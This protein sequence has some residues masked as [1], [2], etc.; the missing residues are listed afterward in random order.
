M[1][2]AKKMKL[3]DIDDDTASSNRESSYQALQSDDKF[4][5]SR[6][7]S[8]LD[9][10]MNDI[11]NRSDI[12]DNEKWLLYNQTLQKFLAYM[13]STRTTS[14]KPST[15]H[16]QSAQS[17]SSIP[18]ER[19][20]S[21]SP[22]DRHISDNNISGIFP[23]RDSLDSITQPVVK[24]FFQNARV[25]DPKTNALQSQLSP[26]SHN[27]S[28]NLQLPSSPNTSMHQSISQNNVTMPS[29]HNTPSPIPQIEG[30][31]KRAPKRNASHSILSGVP[32]SK[33]LPRSLY[34]NRRP[35]KPRH[36]FY[37]EPTNAK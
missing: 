3:I 37:W 28:N 30:T 11:L 22:F 36:V 27:T 26:I 15:I 7:L 18:D 24:E 34:R 21:Y 16:H 32:A 10:S 20:I 23:L 9:N 5:A 31:K 12:D 13:K 17:F 1:K 8:F 25:N 35:V 29:V 14:T 33:V 2:Y 19:N 6:T 4:T